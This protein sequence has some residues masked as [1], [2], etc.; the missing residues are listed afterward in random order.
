M[1]GQRELTSQRMAAFVSQRF[2]T[3]FDYVHD[4]LKFQV[5]A[6]QA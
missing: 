5:R 2:F 6:L 1:M 4:P 3:V